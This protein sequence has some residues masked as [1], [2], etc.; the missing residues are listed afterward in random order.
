[1]TYVSIILNTPWARFIMLSTRLVCRTEELLVRYDSFESW[2]VRADYVIKLILI[3]SVEIRK[4]GIIRITYY[5][6]VMCHFLYKNNKLHAEYWLLLIIY[7]IR[8]EVIGQLI[9]R[10]NLI[11]NK[12]MLNVSNILSNLLSNYPTNSMEP[13]SLEHR[14][15]KHI[16]FKS[17]TSGLL[18][19]V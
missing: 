16:I 6:Y 10:P 8:T 15:Q 18:L 2:V 14:T 1:M 4:L 3:N 17:K 5:W 19:D 12:T 11:Q 7:V 9:T 13:N